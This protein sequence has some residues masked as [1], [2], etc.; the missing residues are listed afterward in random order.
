VWCAEP[1]AERGVMIARTESTDIGEL[2]PDQLGRRMAQNEV[3]QLLDVREPRET[4]DGKIAGARL[5]PLYSLES[6]VAKLDKQ[7]ETIV[8]CARGSR[9]KAAALYLSSI[10]FRRV[11]NLAGGFDRWCAE[12]HS[13]QQKV[14][15]ANGP[16]HS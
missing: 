1:S 13:I 12:G 14:N 8:Y 10:G 2:S 3:F 7:Q 16:E 11:R 4:E 6:A 5:I 15:P 9:G